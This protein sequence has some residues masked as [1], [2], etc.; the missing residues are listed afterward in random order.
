MPNLDHAT[1]L[2]EAFNDADWPRFTELAGDVVYNEPCTGRSLQGADYLEA[3]QGWKM[4]FS[5]LVGDVTSSF[6]ADGHSTIEVV[7]KGTH[8]GPMM[9]PT[10]EQVPATGN[11]TEVPGALVHRYEDGALTNM[12]H[13][14]DLLT[15]L[16]TVGAA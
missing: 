14:F 8:D 9:M 10:G 16:R 5:D 1:A 12:N 3:C 7:W 4:A 11:T 15:I 6:E 2:L 13:Y